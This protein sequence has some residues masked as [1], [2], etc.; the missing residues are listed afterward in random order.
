[1]SGALRDGCVPA[2]QRVRPLLHP[3]LYGGVPGPRDRGD[4]H[5]RDPG[6]GHPRGRLHQLHQHHRRHGHQEAAAAR[7][8]VLPVPVLP[9]CKPQVSQ[10]LH[11]SRNDLQKCITNIA[12]LVAL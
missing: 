9:L 10:F 6:R 1:M 12:H 7:H 4:G 5:R 11:T 8:L 3:Q 2:G